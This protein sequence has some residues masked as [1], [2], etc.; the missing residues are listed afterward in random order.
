[1]FWQVGAEGPAVLTAPDD[2]LHPAQD[3]V[4]DIDVGPG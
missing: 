4:V 3:R 2:G 1:V